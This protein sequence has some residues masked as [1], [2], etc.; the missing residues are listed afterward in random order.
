MCVCS[1]LQG[2]GVVVVGGGVVLSIGLCIER[3]TDLEMRT[4]YMADKKQHERNAGQSTPPPPPQ[5]IN[6]FKNKH[7]Y[8][9]QSAESSY[10]E[11]RRLDFRSIQEVSSCP[12][13]RL[14][15]FISKLVALK[16]TER[17]K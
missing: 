9:H 6:T 2:E 3:A 8:D 11:S 13:W 12:H 15:V 4:D 16:I 5:P 1:C 17:I 14:D 7:E 10:D